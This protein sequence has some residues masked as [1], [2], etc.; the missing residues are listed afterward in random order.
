[1]GTV[2]SVVSCVVSVFPK[3]CTGTDGRKC[4]DANMFVKM[5]EGGGGRP[6]CSTNR[7]GLVW[8]VAARA[9]RTTTIFIMVSHEQRERDDCHLRYRFLPSFKP[10]R[11]GWRQPDKQTNQASNTCFL[12]PGDG[13]GWQVWVG[14]G[15][16]GVMNAAKS[17]R[18]ILALATK[19]VSSPV[20][21]GVLDDAQ[22][23]FLVLLR[24]KRL[25]REPFQPL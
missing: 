13:T 5:L 18:S 24:E 8:V 9:A 11:L 6:L 22:Q 23:S 10:F 20:G 1:M 3:T 7:L 16:T 14:L 12:S 19:L 15:V 25:L 2:A 21:T 17:D 4:G